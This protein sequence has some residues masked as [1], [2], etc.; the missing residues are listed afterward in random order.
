MTSIGRILV[1]SSPYAHE[2][3]AFCSFLSFFVCRVLAAS[4]DDAH[5]GNGFLF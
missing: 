3:C 4:M 5:E 1:A 2:H